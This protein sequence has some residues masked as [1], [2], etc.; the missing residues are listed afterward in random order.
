MA[1]SGVI[2]DPTRVTRIL[3][4]NEAA[5][6]Q[7]EKL[8]RLHRKTILVKHPI[9]KDPEEFISN[10]LYELAAKKSPKFISRAEFDAIVTPEIILQVVSRLYPGNSDSENNEIAQDIYYGKADGSLGPCRK[11]VAVMT[12]VDREPLRVVMDYMNDRISDDCLPFRN[13]S[14]S[15]RCR[16]HGHKHP[17]MN[18]SRKAPALFCHEFTERSQW[19][20]TPFITWTEGA[21]H[22]HYV[23]EEGGPLP[24]VMDSTNTVDGSLWTVSKVMIQPSDGNFG[25]YSPE[26]RSGVYALKQ[27]KQDFKQGSN[28]TYKQDFNY[29]VALSLF[30]Q[31]LGTDSQSKNVQRIKDTRTK[32]NAMIQLLASFEIFDEAQGRNEYFLLFP[33]ADGCLD[34]FWQR[35]RHSPHNKS[36]LEWAV[37]QF[38]GLA[39]ALQL[40][41]TSSASPDQ[42]STVRVNRH[43]G[44]NARN[45][46]FFEH[47]DGHGV[48]EVDFTLM[49]ADLGLRS[50]NRNYSFIDE[51]IDD[52]S[53][54]TLNITYQAPEFDIEGGEISPKTDVWS[55]GCV[56]LEHITWLLLGSSVDD[57]LDTFA[58]ARH[59][60]KDI[61][62]FDTDNFYTIQGHDRASATLNEGV[63]DWIENRLK[64]NPGCV[65]VVDDILLLIKDQ[66]LRPAP[67]ERID[68]H[69]LVIELERIERKWENNGQGD[70]GSRHWKDAISQSMDPESDNDGSDMDSI[71]SLSSMLSSLATTHFSN[72]DGLFTTAV[73]EFAS[74]LS[75]D[76][77]LRLLYETAIFRVG[78][79]RVE[80]NFARLLRQYGRAL[81]LEA[82]TEPERRAAA[83]AAD[84]QTAQC[85]AQEF[86]AALFP[87]E[88]DVVKSRALTEEE[89][90]SKQI[91]LGDWVAGTG[92]VQPRQDEDRREFQDLKQQRSDMGV[93]RAGV[94]PGDETEDQDVTSERSVSDTSQD[95]TGNFAALQTLEEVKGFLTSAAAF[96]TLVQSF[97]VLLRLDKSSAEKN[98][99]GAEG[100]PPAGESSNQSADTP[101][102]ELVEG[103]GN[104]PVPDEHADNTS[105]ILDDVSTSSDRIKRDDVGEN[106]GSDAERMVDKSVD[107]H[108]A[109]LHDH[110]LDTNQILRKEDDQGS[111][112]G[113]AIEIEEQDLDTHRTERDQTGEVLEEAHVP[114]WRWFWENLKYPVPPDCQRLFYTCGCGD[115][116]FLDVRE[117]SP[118]GIRRFKTRLFQ[119][120]AAVKAHQANESPSLPRQ[121]PQAHLSGTIDAT[122]IGGTRASSS[123]TDN[124]DEQ[125]RAATT[126]SPSTVMFQ[127]P[128]LPE[129]QFLLLCVN[130]KN[131]VTSLVHIEVGSFTNDQHLF[132]AISW[133]Y[134]C[135][136]HKHELD[137]LSLLIPSSARKKIQAFL[138]RLPKPS[139]GPRMQK[140]M[141]SLSRTIK[142]ATLHKIASADFVRFQLV[143]V[144]LANQPKWFKVGSF[145]PPE[146]V[147]AKRY[148]Y[149]PVPMDDVEIKDIP[150]PHLLKSG[151]HTDKFWIATF[152]KKLGQPL[153]RLSGAE[154]QSAIG[155]GV[156]INEG[157]NW[158]VVLITGFVTL[159]TIGAGVTVYGVFISA[160]DKEG[161]AFGLGAYLVAVVTLWA[162]LQYTWWNHSNVDA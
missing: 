9:Q 18:R 23:M 41:H 54:A 114:A 107:V 48:G 36:H 66:M 149:L 74:F 50:L 37:Y 84:R 157:L 155:W 154:G 103:G 6:R 39:K 10:A 96:N 19:I 91:R 156:K 87:R 4:R 136:R 89:N 64:P 159:L 59:G 94:L 101:G 25:W 129:F 13:E 152:P 21:P 86:T 77:P 90:I 108:Y 33:W 145:P 135:A 11:L 56:F 119:S 144:G 57:P 118:G 47:R 60:E 81:T 22:N 58:A 38:V 29:E 139:L 62:G 130:I 110:L 116:V 162:S 99:E 82:K 51:L 35:Y 158:A 44:V 7:K 80:R 117:L 106:C 122:A 2:N 16:I 3:D 127:A 67:G 79:E 72:S 75:N 68:S 112:E 15:L 142:S 132:K 61:Y 53:R 151:E 113:I 104:E 43:G 97:R 115:L 55:L 120:V 24:V 141:G 14:N 76:S 46:I 5:Y 148:D 27:L 105:T 150:L 31:K 92:T 42:L 128:A 147:A 40:N 49:F 69:L 12:L 45:I 98:D 65:E 73:L 17:T 83:F 26:D 125:A 34:D 137:V 93:N 153:V 95:G 100:N 63:D 131:L 138:T 102:V 52:P 30:S 124:H 134:Y 20:M 78:P 28:T 1:P 143:P 161:D 85:I 70:Y 88:H 140:I 109:G 126:P 146:E 123:Q 111:A 121:P 160:G 71:F 8:T 32:S 133:E